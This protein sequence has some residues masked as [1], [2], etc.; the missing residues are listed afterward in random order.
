MLGSVGSSSGSVHKQRQ[1]TGLATILEGD[2]ALDT[3]DGLAA[4]DRGKVAKKQ[5]QLDAARAAMLKFQ[6]ERWFKHEN[7]VKTA[8][9][10]WVNEGAQIM[11]DSEVDPY[12][13]TDQR[14]VDWR[15]KQIEIFGLAQGTVQMQK[16]WHD[17]QVK[18]SGAD[19]GAYTPASLADRADYYDLDPKK[20]MKEGL[21]PPPLVKTKPFLNVQEHISKVM[22][23]IN[24][25]L[26]GNTLTDVDRWGIVKETLA[27]PAVADDLNE[28]L[29]NMFQQMRPEE[30]LDL[31]RRATAAGRSVPEQA[32]YDFVTRYET[33]RKA[34]NYDTWKKSLVDRVTVPYKKWDGADSFSK[35]VDEAEIQKIISPIVRDAFVGDDRALAEYEAVL[36]RTPGI[37]DQVYRDQA[38]KHLAGQIRKEI[39]TQEEAG[40]TVRGQDK[41]DFMQ[42]GKD[43]LAAML[44]PDSE[45][46]NEA[47][48]YVYQA[49]DVLGNMTISGSNVVR[50]SSEDNQM[51]YPVW[52]VKLQG[53]LTL[54]DVK[55][56]LPDEV[57]T[58]ITEVQQMGTETLIEIPVTK[59]TENFML[60]IHD[61]K[62]KQT[63]IPFQGALRTTPTK[64]LDQM[65][66]T[67]NTPAK[68]ATGAIPTPVYQFK[69][70]K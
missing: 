45:F 68:A 42:S 34:F 38:E 59:K 46:F 60:S 51:P 37:T 26:N 17:D 39:A 66:G 44:S 30:Q 56:Q 2:R 24:P 22:G 31:N 63:G 50:A 21:L 32:A 55:S 10:E 52:R 9:A 7:A 20:V 69:N 70:R 47:A 28:S 64:T 35:K 18:I 65:G 15:T 61:K 23:A 53:D 41:K 33:Q 19:P 40:V 12:T 54:K 16:N 25:T 3:Y 27:N 11:A 62:L 57:G 1:G 48:G 4:L 49:G 67:T 5:A 14:S 43:W 36:P 29:N 8:L 58:E 13:S 6:P